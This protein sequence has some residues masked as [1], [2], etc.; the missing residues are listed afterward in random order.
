MAIVLKILQ[1]TIFKQTNEDAVQLPPASKVDVPAGRIF[2][3]H[4][5]K[6]IDRNHLRVALVGEYLGE[7]PRN[8]W[9]VYTPH[10]QLLEPA[11]IKVI[12]D[13]VFK[14][15]TANAADLT[16]EDKVDVPAGKVF[17]LHSWAMVNNHYRLAIMLESLGNP[18]RN[19]WYAYAPHMQFIQ[20]QPEV[21]PIP[22]PPPFQGLP[23][24][25]DLNVPYKSQ[26][27]NAYNP[28]GAC[29]VTCFAM[30]MTYF[31]IKGNTGIAQLEDELY[32]YMSKNGL[33]RHDPYDL[34]K[35]A[36]AYG[37]V[38]NFTE[39]GRLQDIRKA[40]AEGR[41]CIIH[42][43][44]TSFG[45]IVVVRG[46]DQYGFFVNDPYGEWTSTGYRNDLSG[47]NLHYSNALIQSKCSPEGEDF[48]W[49]HRL[50]KR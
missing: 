39:R 24:Q 12:R 3:L 20:Q 42:G 13:T 10:I 49:L 18:P 19:T 29:N 9:C 33:S 35:M 1:N 16:A 32:Q 5:W 28:T 48:I 27:D 50:A 14:Q 7:P 23:V 6:V 30:V 37:V 47:K 43:Y 17:N 41:P 25:V 36:Q 44:F 21:V 4:S 38:D 31:K 2:N 15:S 34:M 26:L 11:S 45:H 46:Y 40:I 8:T 22:A